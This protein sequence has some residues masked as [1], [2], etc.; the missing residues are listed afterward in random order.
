MG[1]AAAVGKRINMFSWESGMI[2]FHLT[3]RFSGM[4]HSVKCT[5]YSVTI[6]VPPLWDSSCPMISR[7][8]CGHSQ[9]ILLPCFSCLSELHSAEEIITML[10]RFLS[11]PGA[12]MGL[13]GNLIYLAV[14]DSH[15]GRVRVTVPG[16][17]VY[18]SADVKEIPGCMYAT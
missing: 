15:S 4:K 9:S 13:S 18:R 5:K 10:D 16:T 17:E 8:S 14:R 7:Q 1:K 6:L 11:L 12:E 2:T 3:R